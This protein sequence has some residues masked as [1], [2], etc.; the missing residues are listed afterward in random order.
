MGCF[1]KGCLVVAI[2]GLALAVII[3]GS[4]WYLYRKAL[5]N[6]T[7][8]QPA[9]IRIEPPPSDTQ[10]RAA[11]A[12]LT[13]L[14]EAMANNQEVTVEFT[15]TDL[16]TLVARH[17]DFARERG[18]MRF[19][20]TDSIMTLDF[21]A[22]LDSVPLPRIKG[23]WFNG[24]ARFAF[25]YELG[26]F[27]FDIKSADAGRRHLPKR[28]LSPRFVS[29]FSSSFSKSFSESLQKNQR[30]ADFWQHVKSMTVQG[31]KLVVTTQA[32]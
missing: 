13:R 12:T 19:D 26:H 23:R 5:N 28:M 8:T 21:S 9:D 10:F 17:P 32:R 4:S 16:N 15:A 11:D 20:L 31:D 29:A 30:A 6:F 7:S 24:T 14:R 25:G 27:T 3:A 2:A 1:A 22:P 18:K